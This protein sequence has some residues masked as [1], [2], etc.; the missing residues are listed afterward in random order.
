MKKLYQSR[1]DQELPIALKYNNLLN[2]SCSIALV[3]SKEILANNKYNLSAVL[4]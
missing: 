3:S 1:S 2:H 4:D